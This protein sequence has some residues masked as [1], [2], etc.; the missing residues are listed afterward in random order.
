MA[1][2]LKA[3]EALVARTLEGPGE[4]PAELRRAA[5][6]NVSVGDGAVATLIGKVARHAHRVT[7]EDVAATRA[8]GLTEDQVFEV[9]VSAAVGAAVRQHDAALAALAALAASGME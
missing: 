3:R 1:A 6:D 2:I 9:V 4:A 8:A 5:F 7:D